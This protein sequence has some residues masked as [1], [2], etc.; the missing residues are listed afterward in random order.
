MVFGKKRLQNC[1]FDALVN[2][3][4]CQGVGFGTLWGRGVATTPLKSLISKV[5]STCFGPSGIYISSLLSETAEAMTLSCFLFLAPQK[6]RMSD[7]SFACRGGM[8]GV[9]FWHRRHYKG[10][11]CHLRRKIQNQSFVF[12]PARLQPS[13]PK[14]VL[15]RSLSPYPVVIFLVRLRSVATPLP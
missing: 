5:F 11:A 10:V 1:G 9:S 8:Q 15:S 3:R 12:C 13:L 2:T 4:T 14:M 6:W 7:V